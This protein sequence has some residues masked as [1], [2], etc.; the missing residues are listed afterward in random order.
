M[1]VVTSFLIMMFLSGAGLAQSS[2]LDL[3]QAVAIALERNPQRKAA[4]AEERVAATSIKEAQSAYFPRLTFYETAV[5]SNDPVFVFGTK[6]RQNRFTAAD[7]ALDQ[8]NNPAAIGNFATRIGLQWSAFDSF[9]TRANVRQAASEKTAAAERLARTDQ[10]VIFRV[11]QAYYGVL[12]ASR[13]LEVAEHAAGTAQAVM[14]QSRARFQAGSTVESDYLAAQV[15]DASRRQEVVKARNAL[16]L[17]RAQ[18]NLAMGVA[19]EHDYQAGGPSAPPSLQPPALA[20]AETRALKERPDLKEQAQQI[21]AREAGVQAAKSA[22]G[23]RLNVFAGA[24]ADNVNFF[25]N[26]GNNWTAGAELQFDVFS[27]G[28]KKARLEREHAGLER[29]Q[30]LKQAAEDNVRLEVRRAWYDFD[31]ARQSVEINRMA[32]EQ[33]EEA[34]RIVNNRYQAGM[35][36]ITEMLRSEDASRTARVN[37]WE[38]VYRMSAGYAALELAMGTLNSQSPV[39]MP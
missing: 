1:R 22:F 10:L 36:T 5:I 21:G 13:Q 16:A 34:L 33:A 11:V 18:L 31:S 14:E 17:A 39:V 8:L 35:T 19:P 24:Q 23:P 37:Y 6:L 20:E 3:K 4:L 26:G 32:A 9:L 38:A 29:A 7:F 27:G 25:G 12:F 28:E 15:D 30:S 2:P